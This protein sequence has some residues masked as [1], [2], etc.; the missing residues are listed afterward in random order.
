MVEAQ[1]EIPETLN[2]QNVP[3]ELFLEV[4]DSVPIEPQYADVSFLAHG[5]LPP[6]YQNDEDRGRYLDVCKQK[7]VIP[8]T[9]L[10]FEYDRNSQL[11]V[12]SRRP[13]KGVVTSQY[14]SGNPIKSNEIERFFQGGK[15]HRIEFKS[16]P[17]EF[18]ESMF[19]EFRRNL[20]NLSQEG[21]QIGD[22]ELD[23]TVYHRGGYEEGTY[24]DTEVYLRTLRHPLEREF[25]VKFGRRATSSEKSQDIFEWFNGLKQKYN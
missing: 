12:P 17:S 4:M 9:N 22:A 18:T 10:E 6:R 21:Y 13:D 19:P 7:G 16:R 5:I 15:I 20:A 23:L 24:G 25:S 8:F 14:F 3:Y 11:F 1:Q 2:L